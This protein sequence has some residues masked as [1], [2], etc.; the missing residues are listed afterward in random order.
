MKQTV[1]HILRY[2]RS[3][4]RELVLDGDDDADIYAHQ[5]TFFAGALSCYL[6]ITDREADEHTLAA[7]WAELRQFSEKASRREGLIH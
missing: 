1:A 5:I 7:I 6:A 2:W 3:Y 4:R